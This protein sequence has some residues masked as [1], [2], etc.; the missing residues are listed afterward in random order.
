MRNPAAWDSRQRCAP[1]PRMT[2]NLARANGGPGPK[3]KYFDPY[4]RLNVRQRAA[5][6]GAPTLTIRPDPP[7]RRRPK[8]IKQTRA[9]QA[10][11]VLRRELSLREPKKNRPTLRLL[12][13]GPLVLC[14]AGLLLCRAGLEGSAL[15]CWHR[16]PAGSTAA[17]CYCCFCRP[18]RVRN[19]K[20][21]PPCLF[22]PHGSPEGKGSRPW[23]PG[24]GAV[25]L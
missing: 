20:A 17:A 8:R 21:E 1:A 5:P 12:R 13:C 10:G 19:T 18:C 6:L 25:W 14:A 23:R 7:P 24:G 16:W 9:G 2:L 15:V 3:Y 22:G 11:A 4:T